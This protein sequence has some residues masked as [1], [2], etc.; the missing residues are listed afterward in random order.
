MAYN[1]SIRTKWNSHSRFSIY[2]DHV[3]IKFACQSVRGG[4]LFSCEQS[5]RSVTLA[6]HF[7]Y[8]WGLE[9]MEPSCM[10]QAHRM[11]LSYEGS[12]L[13]RLISTRSNR[14]S[15][16]EEFHNLYSSPRIIG[17]VKSRIIR[18]AGLVARMGEKRNVYVLLVGRPEGKRPLGRRRRR[19][20][21]N[22]NMNF[23][24]IGWGGVHWIGLPQDRDQ[25]KAFVNAVMNLRASWNAGK[26][27]SGYTTKP[28]G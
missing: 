17:T 9:P 23:R 19:W 16:N 10:L 4:G 8:S 21:D 2:V 3:F 20:V 14:L 5:Y 25:R 11:V 18:W 12:T 13:P 27:F 6:T 1:N 15:R 22:I 7:L 26:F 24:E 28:V